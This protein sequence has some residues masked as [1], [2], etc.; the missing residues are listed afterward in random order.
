MKMVVFWLYIMTS[1]QGSITAS[2]AHQV[3]SVFIPGALQ[4][5]WVMKSSGPSGQAA[6][7]S[8]LSRLHL[9]IP[10]KSHTELLGFVLNTR[11]SLGWGEIGCQIHIGLWDPCESNSDPGGQLGDQELSPIPCCK[12]GE[13]LSRGTSFLRQKYFEETEH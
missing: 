3:C 10:G 2:W 6:G 5:P 8:S 13:L 9:C 7:T 4:T 11:G 12:D 1:S